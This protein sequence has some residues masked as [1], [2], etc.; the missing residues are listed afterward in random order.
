[1]VCLV[2]LTWTVL[3]CFSTLCK[4]VRGEMRSEGW[5]C[6]GD[7]SGRSISISRIR[8]AGVSHNCPYSQIDMELTIPGGPVQGCL[9]KHRLQC[10]TRIPTLQICRVA[11]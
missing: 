5:V 4:F 11:M 2:L 9:V 6:K 1:M 10:T 7:N 8:A 3:R